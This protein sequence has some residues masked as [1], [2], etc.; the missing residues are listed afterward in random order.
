MVAVHRVGDREAGNRRA[1]AEL[2]EDFPVPVVEGPEA[3]IH[4][5]V[6]HQPA[7]DDG[8]RRRG[9]SLLVVPRPPPSRSRGRFAT[10]GQD[11]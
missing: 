6:E 4:V 1:E 5:A 10:E 9:G 2:P 7:A 8:Q 11:V 3:P